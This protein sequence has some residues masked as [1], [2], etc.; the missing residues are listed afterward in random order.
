[1]R[2]VNITADMTGT[3]YVTGFLIHG[4]TYHTKPYHLTPKEAVIF[5]QDLPRIIRQYEKACQ[6]RIP[7]RFFFTTGLE[8]GNLMFVIREDGVKVDEGYLFFV[9]LQEIMRNYLKNNEEEVTKLLRKESC[10]K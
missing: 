6:D 7:D 9:S 3:E 5:Y 8:S 10:T 1:M 4:L 2:N